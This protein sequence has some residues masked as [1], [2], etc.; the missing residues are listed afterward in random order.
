M[1]TEEKDKF[2]LFQYSNAEINNSKFE[3]TSIVAAEYVIFFIR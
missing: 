2:P 3:I 1:K